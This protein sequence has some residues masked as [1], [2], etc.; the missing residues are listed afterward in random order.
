MCRFH[1]DTSESIS[2]DEDYA[3]IAAAD[4]VRPRAQLS[5]LAQFQGR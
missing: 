3:G 4:G 1:M 2:L 5:G